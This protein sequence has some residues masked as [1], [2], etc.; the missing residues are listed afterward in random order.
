M[1]GAATTAS[2]KSAAPA[3]PLRWDL[4]LLRIVAILGVVAI[5]VFAA[6]AVSPT[7]HGTP[8]W[9]YA[10]IVDIGAIWAVPMFILV[11]GALLLEPRMHRDGPAAFYRRRAARL[12][13]PLV[14]WTAFYLAVRHWMQGEAMPWRTVL[15]LLID[16]KANAAM[17]FLW[18]I[19]GLYLVAPILVSF[20]RE[21]GPRRA[22]TL[23]LAWMGW[24][25]LLAALPTIT[26]HLG[27]PRPFSLTALTMW[28]PYVGMFVAGWAWRTPQ[29]TGRRVW[30]TAPATL[31]LG[32]FVV[33]QWAA[34]PDHD[35]LQRLLPVGYYTISVALLALLLFIT[36]IDLCARVS[37]PE[38]AAGL[39]RTLGQATFGVFLVHL[40]L[41]SLLTRWW[42][43]FA[44]DPAPG[45]RTLQW[46]VVV[47]ASFA[48]AWV[49]G[50]VPGVRRL[51]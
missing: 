23:A 27:S 16:A 40:F 13:P 41:M 3:R 47:A 7:L 21:G 4:D 15:L 9:W 12:V 34:R 32:A 44:S 42:P 48:V 36:V 17:Y 37:L 20:L 24:A 6:V 38:S 49:A 19:L 43:E 1:S 5:H 39:I 22:R 10:V 31:A 28:L 33:W 8:T 35:L 50:R 11:S 18:L 46:A 14:F 26:A 29:P 51:V 30:F 2:P 25:S 45:P